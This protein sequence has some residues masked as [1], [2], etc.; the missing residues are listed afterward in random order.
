MDVWL[1]DLKASLSGDDATGR[2]DNLKS[3]IQLKFEFLSL[4]LIF[5]DM[6]GLAVNRYKIIYM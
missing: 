5:T 6:I 2:C 1:A 4:L 3:F